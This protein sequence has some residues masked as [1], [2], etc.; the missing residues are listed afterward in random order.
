M[1]GPAMPAQAI[2]RVR[3]TNYGW[4]LEVFSLTLGA[5]YLA[6]LPAYPYAASPIIKGLSIAALAVLPWISKPV[7]QRRDAGLLS[8]ALVASSLGDVF[9]DVG[10][11]PFFVPGLC[12]FLTAHLIYTVLFVRNRSR[13]RSIGL[14]RRLGLS[15][16]LVYAV[17]FSL[18]LAPGLGPLKVPVVL[19][20]C[21]ITAMIVS[22]LC[23]RFDWRVPIGALLFLASDSLL[24]A[25]KFKA[26]FTGRGYLVWATYYTAQYL[27]VT[28]ALRSFRPTS[29]TRPD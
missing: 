15:A 25:G 10:P 18:W 27:I 1:L 24:A 7:A 29:F 19:Y 11:E 20:I 28:G 12:A 6:A 16:V 2:S 4:V 5:G 3:Q 13:L 8:A 23:S 14:S 9:L 22:A 21:A 17:L 26:S